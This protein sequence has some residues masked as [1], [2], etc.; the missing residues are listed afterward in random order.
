MRNYLDTLEHVWQFGE[1]IKRRNGKAKKMFGLAARY[2][3]VGEQF[4]LP[5]TKF[6]PFT[7][8]VAELLCFLRGYSKAKDFRKM[9]C[10]VW[11]AN[12]RSDYWKANKHYKRG[13]LGRIYG[14]Q[15]RNWQGVE[16]TTDEE[17]NEYMDYIY[18]DQIAE[19]IN[20]LKDD[21]QN[22]GMV[23][24]AWNAGELDQMCLRPCHTLFQADVSANGDLNLAMYQRSCDMFLGVPFNI[25]SYS[26]LILILC[27]QTGLTP[28]SFTHFMGNA[29]IYDAHYD[30]VQEQLKRVP[31]TSP[32]VVI[33]R[34]PGCSIEDY[35]VED[36]E[37][38]GYEPQAKIHGD[39]IV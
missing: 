26:L 22:S 12:A 11:N 31:G 8:I 30:Q 10:N 27:H 21:P 3:Q 34:E 9:G 17:G 5:T 35:E 24:S 25:A 37:L 20:L 29:H 13:S 18:I 33:N 36:F 16:V 7:P 23:V 4:P 1:E 14:V 6:L 39:M 19:L 15:W 2:S 28:G 38:I 32:R